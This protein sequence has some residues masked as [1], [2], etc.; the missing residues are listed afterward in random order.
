MLRVA[1]TVLE[2]APRRSRRG[3]SLMSWRSNAF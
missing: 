2:N 3:M 1:D